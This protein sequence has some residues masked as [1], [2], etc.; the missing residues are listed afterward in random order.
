MKASH[1]Q[2]GKE[3]QFFQIKKM[4]EDKLGSKILIRQWNPQF[5][6]SKFYFSM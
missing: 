5:L 6:N 2:L 3:V 4:I 1:S